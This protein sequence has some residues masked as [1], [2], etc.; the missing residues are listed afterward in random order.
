MSSRIYQGDAL[1]VLRTLPD[2]SVHCVVTSPPYWGLRDYGVDGQLGLEECVDCGW[3]G[4][5]ASFRAVL[6]TQG[7][8]PCGSCFICRMV[9]V[10]SEVRR[11][12]RADGT[13][14]LNMG[15]GYAGSWGAQGRQ[16]KTGLKPK[17]M[18]G[19]PWRL[20]LALQASGWW[21]RSDIIWH[22]LN[23]MPEAVKDRPTSAHEH[24]F[25][26]SKSQKY[27]YDA[28]AVKYDCTETAHAGRTDGEIGPMY[29]DGIGKGYNNRA[30]TWRNT[31]IAV[32]A[33]LRNVW[34][35]VAS[36]F[37]EAHFATFPPALVEPCIK[38][39]C[40]HGGIVLDPFFGSGTVGLVARRLGRQVVGIELSPKYCRM[41]A[42]RINRETGL[43]GPVE[44]IP[45]PCT[46]LQRA[47]QVGAS[48]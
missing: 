40:P 44:I 41:A 37:K 45:A 32:K 42:D 36:G 34:P 28:D 43:L 30:G 9:A 5:P 39:G 1:K 17:D 3:Y 48:S 7:V 46:G 11:V 15:D 31:Y 12:L 10:F 19:Q 27:Y 23:P 35:V 18:I 16:G 6:A 14:W 33:N 47:A 24:I 20:A 26:L 25:L 22:K 2:E 29:E 38:A 8:G 13:L 4:T 21:L